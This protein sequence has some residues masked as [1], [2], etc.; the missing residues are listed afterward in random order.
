MNFYSMILGYVQNVDDG[1]VY[2]IMNKMLEGYEG[3]TLTVDT[4]FAGTRSNAD[5]SGSI[6]GVTTEN[7]TPSALTSGVLGG[8][9]SE[10]F[11]M[12]ELMNATKSGIVG[13]GN[14][15][16][17]NP[18]L[19]K[20]FEEKFQM[21]MNIPNHIEEAAFGAALFALISQGI[22]RNAEEA[23]KLIKYC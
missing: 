8:M 23:Q 16:R 7:F 15:I 11:E 22:F 6:S 1:L 14:G 3:S 5:I 13:S 10:L 2:D 17:K 9:V 21:K 18:A 20:A 19:V 4:R 12:Y